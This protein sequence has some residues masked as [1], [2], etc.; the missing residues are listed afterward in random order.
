MKNL[1]FYRKIA[2]FFEVQNCFKEG[3][4]RRGLGAV[5]I[6]RVWKFDYNIF[7]CWYRR[8][9]YRT[10]SQ[11]ERYKN[12]PVLVISVDNIDSKGKNLLQLISEYGRDHVILAEVN[13]D[14]FWFESQKSP[15]WRFLEVVVKSWEQLASD[16]VMDTYK[17]LG[18]L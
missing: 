5:I 11:L 16:E 3:L 7:N 1:H 17:L 6:E 15:S 10:I 2:Q 18:E 14:F 13:Y 9:I 8:P 12:I 4:T